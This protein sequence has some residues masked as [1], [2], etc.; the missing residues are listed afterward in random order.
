MDLQTR[1]EK[2]QHA[3]HTAMQS[4]QDMLSDPNPEVQ[5]L[6]DWL[7]TTDANPYGFLREGWAGS[8]EDSVGF[9]A[10][11]HRIHHAL[12]DDG[13]IHFIVVQKIIEI[14]NDTPKSIT[15]LGEPRITFVERWAEG[16][17]TR[18]LSPLELN[19]QHSTRKNSTVRY[20]IF[21]LDGVKEFIATHQEYDI[22]NL[23]RCFLGDARR[24]LPAAILHYQP[25]PRFQSDW[26]REA[27]NDPRTR[28]VS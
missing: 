11:C 18:M 22:Q 27:Q 13:E 9:A 19:D 6:I 1:C 15:V 5:L 4:I 21:Y 12:V 14:Q 7:V 24:D 2:F 20:E 3:H 16:H 17:D 23:R 28:E 10:L 8:M 26:I 25:N